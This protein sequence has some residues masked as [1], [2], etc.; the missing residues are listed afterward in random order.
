MS[1][2]YEFLKELLSGILPGTFTSH[3]LAAVHRLDPADEEEE[4]DNRGHQTCPMYRGK[5]KDGYGYL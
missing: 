2:N 5:G 1:N 3:Q 4:E